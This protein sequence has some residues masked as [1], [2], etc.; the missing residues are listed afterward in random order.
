MC[1]L[2]SLQRDFLL[3]LAIE[4]MYRPVWSAAILDELEWHESAKLIK[5]G[6][7]ED[8]ARLRAKAL[9][10]Q[11]RLAFDDAEV[12]G[13][14][15]LEGT[16]GLPDLDDEHVL[17]AAFVAGAGAIVTSNIRDFPSEK[18]PAGI[19]ILQP[20]EFAANTVAVDPVRAHAAVTA[21]AGR[22]GRKGPPLTTGDVLR[23]LS[24]R[25]DMTRVVEL[26][27]QVT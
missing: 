3:S 7:G 5:R 18:V 10:R 16:Y 23:I 24:D 13:W 21:I 9:I 15:A 8:V 6:E 17:A 22:S 26:L 12:R 25:Y 14:E 11:M 2:A 4:G 20:A 19:Q 1:A 27:T